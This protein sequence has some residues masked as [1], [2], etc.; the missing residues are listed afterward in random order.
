MKGEERRLRLLVRQYKMDVVK[1]L[2]VIAL[3]VLAC[4]DPYD[5][6]PGDPTKPNPPASPVLRSPPDGYSTE[7]YVYPQD[8]ELVWYPVERAEFYQVRVYRDSL[9]Q[10]LVAANDRVRLVSAVFSFGVGQYYWCVRAASRQWNDYTGW[11]VTW[12]FIIP[13]PAR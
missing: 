10:Q 7:K 2:L 8:V 9:R 13:S 3:L 11:S 4:K 6:E 1:R 12:R 5:F